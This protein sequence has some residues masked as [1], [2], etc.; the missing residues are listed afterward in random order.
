MIVDAEGN[1]ITGTMP[2]IGTVSYPLDMRTDTYHIPAGYHSGAGMVYID[3]ENKTYTPTKSEAIIQ[4]TVGKVLR[5]VTV[6]PIPDKYIDTTDAD[7]TADQ[8]LEDAIAYV[9]GEKLTGTMPNNG[10][11]SKTLDATANNQTYTVPV[12][13]HDGTGAVSI[14]LENKTATPSTATQNITPATGKVLSKVT[15][16]PI[17][18]NWGDT[19]GDTAVAANILSGVTAHSILNGSAVALEGTMPNNGSA[20]ATMDGLTTTSVT[21]AAGYTTGGT[22]SLTDDIEQALAA[23]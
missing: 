15:V 21:I 11:V 6:R 13:Y 8:I 2:N 14:V 7:A 5:T 9:D 4:P 10:G 18:A 3:L 19:T 17:P 16:N 1:T 22:V 12:G 23:I 20:T